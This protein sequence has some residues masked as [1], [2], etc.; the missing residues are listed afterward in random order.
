MNVAEL[1]RRFRKLSN[2]QVE[3]Y[4][5]EDADLMDWINDAVHEACIRGRLLHESENADLCRIAVTAGSSQYPLDLRMYELT[6]IR[7]ESNAGGCPREVQLASEEA[8]DERYHGNWRTRTGEPERAVQSDTALRLVPRPDQ[9]GTLILEGYRLPMQDMEQNDDVPEI[10][11]AHHIHLIQWVLHKAFSVPDTEFFDS[12]RAQIAEMEF[13]EYFGKR[14]DSDL[15]RM[16]RED[17]QQHVTA[18]WP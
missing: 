7:F 2:D 15:R 18:I 13:T 4:F 11:Q 10:S 8:L 12:S 14:P 9:D 16:V 5:N 17:Y 1:I 3:P 6:H